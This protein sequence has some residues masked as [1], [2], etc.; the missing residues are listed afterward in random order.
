MKS[1]RLN[2]KTLNSGKFWDRSGSSGA[3]ILVSLQLL[4]ACSGRL[5]PTFGNS[6]C[7]ALKKSRGHQGQVVLL[8][9]FTSRSWLL[10]SPRER[11]LCP[12]RTTP[13]T[14]SSGVVRARPAFGATEAATLA[15]DAA[16]GVAAAAA[17]VVARHHGSR[18]SRGP[19]PWP[20]SQQT[21]APQ[22]PSPRPSP[23][24]VRL[25]AG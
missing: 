20:P 6:G 19:S 22:W 24:V 18:R 16:A 14:V 11:C 12:G 9:D 17:M 5:G 1:C 23:L 21:R 2:P 25:A 15:A 4:G 10:G 7:P 8:P 13:P 3:I